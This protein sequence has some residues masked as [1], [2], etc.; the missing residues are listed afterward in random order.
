M[1]HTPGPWTVGE[2]NPAD[3]TIAIKAGKLSP[4]AYCAPRP[5]WDDTQKAN[6]RLIAAAPDLL[7]ALEGLYAECSMFHKQWGDRS[8]QKAADKA[9]EAG[10]AAIA[11]AKRAS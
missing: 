3:N 1:K 6:A 5:H 10:L 8:N 11:K 7:Q 4:L 9:I 2:Q